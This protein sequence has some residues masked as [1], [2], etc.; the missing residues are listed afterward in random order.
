M[1]SR[2]PAYSA[3][4][5]VSIARGVFPNRSLTSAH[6]TYTGAGGQFSTLRGKVPIHFVCVSIHIF[7]RRAHAQWERYVL[8]T[9]WSGYTRGFEQKKI[10]KFIALYFIVALIRSPGRRFSRAFGTLGG[11]VENRKKYHRVT[12]SAT[13]V[14]PGAT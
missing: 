11:R 13:S 14:A 12:S 10:I 8:D 5:S 4:G 7:L 9:A 2:E 3:E 1:S 6:G